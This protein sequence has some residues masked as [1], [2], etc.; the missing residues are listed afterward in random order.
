MLSEAAS[1][2]LDHPSRLGTR[3]SVAPSNETGDLLLPYMA[4]EE[5]TSDE[6]KIGA[7]GGDVENRRRKR[8][9]RKGRRAVIDADNRW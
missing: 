3:L 1:A 8:R 7:L 2:F 4:H 6:E 5:E 9:Q